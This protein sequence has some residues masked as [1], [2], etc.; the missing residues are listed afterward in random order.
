MDFIGPYPSGEYVHVIIDTATRWVE[1]SLWPDATANSA[2]L[3]LLNHIGR[4]GTPRQIRSDRGSH[5]ANH[6]IKE[7]LELVGTP[8][9]LTLAYSSEENAIVE[10]ANKE[11]NRHLRALIF[12][13]P[14]VKQLA[15]RL[16]FVMRIL[17]TTKNA[18]TGLAP[19]QLL[20]GNVIDLDEGILL[21]RSER[22]QFQSLLDA[23][24][25]MIQT[26]DE[27]CQKA[28]E[29]RRSSDEL[30][31]ASQNDNITT[32]EIGSYVL[33][34][35]TDQPPT[36][37]HTLWSGPFQV[38]NHKNSEYKLLD[39]VTKKEKLVHATRIKEFRFNPEEVDPLDIARRDTL[40]FF[41]EEIREHRG[42]PRKVSTLQFLV[43]WQNYTDEHNTWESWANL[44]LVGALHKYLR[45]N[46]MTKLIPSTE[47]LKNRN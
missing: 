31:L 26:Q 43:K 15:R 13:F 4:Y 10:R 11:I 19:A 25:D 2:A 6:L 28:A 39:L 20:F 17:N 12:D 29:L 7:F 37:L 18:V 5:F 22:P 44:R 3:A 8:H 1:I 41:V 35:Y 47:P 33:V 23:T 27:L 16:P 36:R 46:K 32:F 24:N 34:K 38:L 30:H 45:E 40:E 21:P 42:N 14:E 9:N